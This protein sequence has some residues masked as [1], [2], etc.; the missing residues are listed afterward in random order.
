MDKVEEFIRPGGLMIRNVT[1][2]YGNAQV[3]N[4]SNWFI[5]ATVLLENCGPFIII[6]NILVK[7]HK[8]SCR[9]II[10]DSWVDTFHKLMNSQMFA[11][12]QVWQY[13]HIKCTCVIFRND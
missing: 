6:E 5:S 1:V 3:S 2:E 9:D 8:I 7:L 4:I 11:Y 13:D 12:S 10:H